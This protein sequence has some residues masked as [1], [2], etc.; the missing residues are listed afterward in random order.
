MDVEALTDDTH[1]EVLAML[2]PDLMDLTDL[3][4]AAALLMSLLAGAPPELPASVQVEDHQ[5][6][7]TDGQQIVVRVYRPRVPRPSSPCLYWMHGGWCWATSRWTMPG[8][9]RSWNS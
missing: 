7:A 1:R 8:A 2:P 5:V 6:L 3:E 4:S 9:P